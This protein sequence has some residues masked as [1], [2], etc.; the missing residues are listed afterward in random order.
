MSDSIYT[1]T[2]TNLSDCSGNILTPATANFSYYIVKPYDVVFNEIMAD[3]DPV[4]TILPNYEYVE[5][6][7][8]TAFPI[9]LNNWKFSAGTSTKILPS[10][11]VPADSF[12]VLTSALG[13]AG[14][15]AGINAEAL[16]SFP[17]L[18]NTGQTLTLKD[19]QGTYTDYWYL[20]AVKK[21]GGYSLEQIDP[22]NP[23]E[24]MTNWQGSNSV[25]GGTPGTQNSVY[26]SNPDNTPPQVLRVGVIAVDTIQLFFNEPL[27]SASMINPA[28]YAID[29]SIGNPTLVQVI[30]PDFKSVRL[31]LGTI[32]SIGT[33]YTITVNNAITDC[34]GNALGTDNSARF[35]IPEPA[36]PNDI[37]INEILFNPVSPGVDFVEIY[38]RS[39]KV[40][41]LKTISISEYDT[42][43][44]AISGP[45]TI[46][47]DGYLIFPQEYILLSENG[48]F[49]QTQFATTNPEGFLDVAN[50]STM[51]DDGGTVCL[52]TATDIIDN[53]KYYDNM[54]F[55]LLNVTEGISLERIDFDRLT[56][57]RTN[58]HSA[59]EAVGFATPAYKNSQ[60]SDAGETEDAIEITPE[61]FSPD[62]DGM[63]DVVNI[64]YHF[65]IPGFVANVNVYDSKGRI[66][67][68]LIQSE[69]LGVKGT[70]S[71]DGIN[72][73]REKARIG[74]Y[75]FYFEVFDL[76]GTVKH[77]KKTCVLAG[78]L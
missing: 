13:L 30:A 32:L 21:D 1:L 54:H 18:T 64:N 11:I 57:D 70:F 45:E 59:A 27:D 67:K 2:L 36:S 43:T 15:P 56:Q 23:C 12:I 4:L 25:D 35:A 62:E 38:N 7:N 61:I 42:I 31:T 44:N 53:F 46:S 40:I 3:P 73:D 65:D 34:V 68:H 55:G 10:I 29:N 63:N 75:I 24:G 41:D 8:K 33:I 47:A 58:W 77:Y 39:N 20:D 28:L 9:N 49:V 76:S 72:D 14:M 48:A 78:K 71:W 37:V 19:P 50:L 17:S 51:N 52:S 66:V 60:Y 69:L 16:I 26:A 5:L 74:I 6:Y 22:T